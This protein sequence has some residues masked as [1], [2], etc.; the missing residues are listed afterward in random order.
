MPDERTDERTGERT[1]ERADHTLTLVPDTFS[2]LT[3]LQ[4]VSFAAS[5]CVLATIFLLKKSLRYRSPLLR[6]SI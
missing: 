2:D 5:V 4:S 1:G 3:I 6:A